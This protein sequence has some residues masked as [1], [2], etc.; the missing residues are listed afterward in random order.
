MPRLVF[1]FT[2][3]QSFESDQVAQTSHAPMPQPG[4]Q[5]I[6][7]HAVLAFPTCSVVTTM[8]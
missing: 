4:E 8:Q 3:Y 2:V 1:G 7:G 5:V 6:G